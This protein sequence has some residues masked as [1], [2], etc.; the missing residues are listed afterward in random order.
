M[1]VCHVVVDAMKKP[2]EKQVRLQ[3][4]K[5]CY[6]KILDLDCPQSGGKDW[7]SPNVLEKV[8]TRKG[9]RVALQH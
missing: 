8:N 5:R 4:T 6:L 1:S 9:R 3:Y 7:D 2:F